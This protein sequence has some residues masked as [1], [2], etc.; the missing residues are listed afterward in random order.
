LR[1][2]AQ[3]RDARNVA[4]DLRDVRRDALFPSATVYDDHQARDE[5][6]ALVIR[7]PLLDVAGALVR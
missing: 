3:A 5:R 2:D 6:E 4:G 1:G 7:H